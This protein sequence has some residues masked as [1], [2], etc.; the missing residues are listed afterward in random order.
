MV[1]YKVVGE[2][3]ERCL[4]HL[5]QNRLKKTYLQYDYWDEMQNAWDLLGEKLEALDLNV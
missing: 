4:N 2:V 3:V 5:E 1:R